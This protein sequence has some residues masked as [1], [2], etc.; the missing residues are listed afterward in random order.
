MNTQALNQLKVAHNTLDQQA[1]AV[2]AMASLIQQYRQALTQALIYA[3]SLTRDYEV[4]ER[5]IA[6]TNGRPISSAPRP[7]PNADPAQPNGSRSAGDEMVSFAN[8]E[9]DN[10][11]NPL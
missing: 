7:E 6:D 10:S 2:L 9:R 11:G 8:L 1:T 3:N 5:Q 4:L